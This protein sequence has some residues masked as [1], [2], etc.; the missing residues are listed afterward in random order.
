LAFSEGLSAAFPP[1]VIG[2]HRDP[3][4]L[5]KYAEGLRRAGLPE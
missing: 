5:L 4:E 3:G 1:G 2:P